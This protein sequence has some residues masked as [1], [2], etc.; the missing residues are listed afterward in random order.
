MQQRRQIVAAGVA[1]L[2]L[3]G[4]DGGPPRAGSENPERTDYT[5]PSAAE[6]DAATATAAPNVTK[7]QE[8]VQDQGPAVIA[9]P[10]LRAD[11]S[12]SAFPLNK[13]VKPQAIGRLINGDRCDDEDFA[14]E[15]QDRSGTRHIFG[16][17]ILAIKALSLESYPGRDV[18]ALG[19][20]K[21][22]DRKEVVS[23]VRAFLPEI[24]ISCLDAGQA[25]EGEGIASCSGSFLNG[26]WFKLLFDANG[27]LF[28]ARIDAF[29]MN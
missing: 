21:A 27:Q 16:G 4:C 11:A 3:S 15:W 1:A 19:I 28:E 2:L 23:R 5:V 17:D 22:R 14:C 7:G 20:G 24:K 6:A 26:G 8:Q 29:Q 10:F 18:K 9:D 12:F 13:K 25:G